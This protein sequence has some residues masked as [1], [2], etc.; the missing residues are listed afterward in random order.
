M[1]LDELPEDGRIK[2]K[3]EEKSWANQRAKRRREKLNHQTQEIVS[4]RIDFE[5]TVS[6]FQIDDKLN[7]KLSHHQT[8]NSD[9]KEWLNQILQYV[10]N[11][12]VRNN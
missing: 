2:L 1:I 4:Q 9:C 12:I 3:A 11:K 10:K 5:L 7:L 8:T 6:I